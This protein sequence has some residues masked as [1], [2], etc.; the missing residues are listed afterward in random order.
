M[1]VVDPTGLGGIDLTELDVT[2]LETARGLGLRSSPWI[3]FALRR[4]LSLVIVLVVLG[5]LA[6]GMVRLIPG[7]PAA[8]V[9][10]IGATQEQTNAVRQQLGLDEPIYVQFVTYWSNAAHG[11]LGSS[12]ITHQPV[13]EVISQRIGVS[14]QL[15]AVSLLLVLVVSIPG[16][17]LAGAVTRDGIHRRLEVGFTAATSVVGSLPE[18][19]AGT[20]LAFIF[21]VLLRLLPVAGSEGWQSIILPALAVSLRP[22]AIL[23]RLV[24]VETLNVLATDYMTTAR[25]KRLPARLVYLRHALP[26]VVTAALT[27][28][29]ILF[30]ALIGGAVVVENVFA[31]AGLGTA[32][33]QAV[34]QRDYPV[35]Q[36]IILVLGVTV[37]TINAI[38]D[39]L[40]AIIDPRSLSRRA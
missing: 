14:L 11:N 7:D 1:S 26:N 3:S 22:M 39:L 32:L 24:R 10:G 40:L 16:G 36:G 15:A 9:G 37:V 21:A 28:G 31:R 13:T 19:L 4:L 20:F 33:V 30:A 6:F 5:I 29:G 8:I 25:S 17:M 12:F 27:I 34:I 23:S 38:V 18:Y 35:I 2:P